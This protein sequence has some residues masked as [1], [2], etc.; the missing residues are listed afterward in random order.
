MLNNFKDNMKKDREIFNEKSNDYL[1]IF[2]NKISKSNN[3]I[4]KIKH[5]IKNN[6]DLTNP[7][8]NEFQ[9]KINELTKQKNSVNNEHSRAVNKI[10]NLKEKK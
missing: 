8:K 9:N 5:T 2:D 4:F 3:K 1:D 6:K 7:E 10:K